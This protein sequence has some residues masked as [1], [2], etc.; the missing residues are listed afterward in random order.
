MVR[1]I[2]GIN[3]FDSFIDG[4]VTVAV[5]LLMLERGI[6]LATI[7]IVFAITP[8]VKLV[9]RMISSAVADKR[10][11]KAFYTLNGLANLAQAIVLVFSHSPLLFGVA[12]LFNGARTAFIW[13]VNRS[14]LIAQSEGKHF[15]LTKMSSGR[16][17]Y[18]A[19]GSVAVFLLYP[20]GGFDILFALVAILAIASMYFSLGVKNTPHREKVKWLDMSPFGR[21][22]SFYQTMA[23]MMT[24]TALYV[25]VIYLL[26][27]IYFSLAGFSLADISLLYAGY[28]FIFGL[29]LNFLS[30]RK[31][32]SGRAALLG[33]ALFII[34]LSG[35]SFAP[36]GYWAVFFLLMAIGDA[37]LN[38]LWE[39]IIYLEAHDSRNKS[40]VIGLLHVP[41]E[42]GMVIISAFAGFAVAVVGFAPLFL[43]GA[44]CMAL[45]SRMSLSLIADRDK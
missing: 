29:A 42:L 9:L 12:R 17:F 1:R 40:I 30:H 39:H 36:S 13:A 22:K 44:A 19:L 11:E 23:A 45:Y 35:L 25:V 32:D 24:G 4:I 7:G 20:K 26:I 14:S 8:L 33:S 6:D 3:F 27:P 37:C 38:L 31:L 10:G 34:C 15:T 18:F 5:P 21:R 43:L 41:G 16:M 28:F 2:F